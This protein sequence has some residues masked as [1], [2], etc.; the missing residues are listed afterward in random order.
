MT[1]FVYSLKLTKKTGNVMIINGLNIVYAF[2]ISYFRY[3]EKINIVLIV[4]SVS[5]FISMLIVIM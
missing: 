1:M 3:G 4:G 2:A 5:L